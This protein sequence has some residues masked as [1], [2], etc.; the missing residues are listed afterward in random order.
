MDDV[1]TNK[2]TKHELEVALPGHVSLAGAHFPTHEDETTETASNFFNPSTIHWT[3]K[4]Y[5]IDL[6]ARCETILKPTIP[7][8]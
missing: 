1:Q 2:P 7:S 5:H 8:T 4:P 6:K 3:G